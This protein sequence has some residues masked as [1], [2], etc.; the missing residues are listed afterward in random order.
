MHDIV[1]TE[2]FHHVKH[3][4]QAIAQEIKN[5]ESVA[6]FATADLD[7]IV[8]LAFL[9][10]AMMDAK[11]PYSR[12]I[13]KPTQFQPKGEK[14]N[15]T[16]GASISISIEQFEETWMHDEIDD[17]GRSRIV[18]LAISVSHPNSE[19][20]HNGALDV[21]V[22]CAAIA[23]LIAPNGARVRRLR[24]LAGSGQWLRQS[25]DNSY[26]PVYTKIRDI[27]QD[28]G[29]IR[30][31]PIPEID[32]P[33]TSMIPDFPDSLYKRL[34]K[35]WPKMDFN[36]RQQA[37]SELALPTLSSPK[38]STPRLEELLWFRV[39]IDDSEMDLHSQIHSLKEHWPNEEKSTKSYAAALL[40]RLISTGKLI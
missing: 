5:C 27:L 26:D 33:I 18:P 30:I 16:T 36:Q 15:F 23:S 9:E 11:I 13:L 19:K 25:L 22:Q 28:E 32:S 4:V 21:V 1:E 34:T 8:S 2:L 29:S 39:V 12:K 20:Q 7:S 35:K 24:P 40:K 17:L 6:L 31:L 37:M 14:Y 38:L 3:R 10:S